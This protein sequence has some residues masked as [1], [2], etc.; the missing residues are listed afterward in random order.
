[1]YHLHRWLV[2]AC[3][4]LGAAAYADSG[5]IDASV[6]RALVAK[7]IQQIESQALPPV[8][9]QDYDAAKR[10]LQASVAGGEKELDRQQLYKDINRMLQTIDSGGHTML[11]THEVTER[12]IR[13]APSAD[14]MPGQVRIV[15]TA[16]GAALVLNMPPVRV[17]TPAAI[18]AYIETILR[19]IAATSGLERSCA[20]V[21]D[22]TGQTGG[23]AWPQ[24]VVLE[25]LFSPGNTSRFINRDN[26]RYPLANPKYF[27]SVKGRIGPLPPNALE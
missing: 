15:E 9:K 27:E 19:N 1:M 6:A 21:I 2:A 22:L 4:L 18:Q 14:S 24:M 25:P 3:L 7:I 12:R 16:Q 13:N 20:L 8:S 26:V 5:K 10:R 17:T 23:A 11:W